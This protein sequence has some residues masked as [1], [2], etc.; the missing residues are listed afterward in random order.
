LDTNPNDQSHGEIEAFVNFTKAVMKAY[1]K[2]PENQMKEEREHAE[3]QEEQP[4]GPKTAE[5]PEFEDIPKE[6]LTSSLDINAKLTKDQRSKLEKILTINHRAFSLDGRIGKYEDIKYKIRVEPGATPISLPPYSASL[7]KRE[8]IDKQLDKW[9]SQEVIEPSD[10]PWGA[11]VIVVYRFGKPRVCIDYRGVNSLSQPDEYPLPKQTDILQA[12]MG[13]Q[14]LSTF[15]TL[16]GFQQ[17]EIKET[18]RPISAFRCHRG[19]LQFKRLPFGLR[20]GP[21]VFQ[22]IMNKVLST[23]LWLFVLV[24]IDDIV[25]Y[26]KTFEDHL[27]HLDKVL[28]AII[29]ANITLSPPKCHIGYQSLILLGQKVSRLG[30]STLKEKV[31]AI[32]VLIPPI[33]VSELQSFLGMVNYFSNY[34]PFY[35][36]ITRP[37]Y[38]LLRKDTTWIW[39]DKQQRAFDLC[40]EALTAAPVLGYPIPGLGYRLYTDASDHG[41]GVVLQ[42]IQPIK[43]KDLKG[44]KTY[45]RL[46]DHYLNNQPIPLLTTNIKLE[47][48]HIPTNLLWDKEFEET[49]VWVERVIAYWSRL[50]KQ[51]EK[52]Y[53]ATEKEAL[54]LKEALVKFQ[55]V[56]EGEHIMAI[57]DHSALTWSKTY[58]NVNKRLQKWGLTYNAYPKLKIIHRARRVHSNVYPISRLHRR[59]PW[60]ESP[61]FL[62]DPQIELK[63][64]QKIDFY[65]KYRNK[66]ESMAYKIAL[67]QQDSITFTNI[68]NESYAVAYQ[69]SNKMETQLHFNENDIREWI[70]AYEKDKHYSEVLQ[71]CGVSNTKFSQYSLQEDGIIIFNNWTGYSRVCVPKSLVHEILKEI[72]DGITG[73]AHA[74]YDK[75]YKRISQIFYWLKMS[76]DIKKFVYSCPICQQIKHKRH[77]PYGILQL[78]PIPDKPF[79]VVTM[80]LITDLP[81]SENYNAIYV[82][83]CKL[84]KYAFFIPCTTKLSEKEAAKIFFDNIVCHVGLPIQI[85]SD[86]DSRWRNDFWKEVCQYM[87]S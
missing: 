31:D 83:V 81:E 41:I 42:Q 59:I 10:S 60:Y 70:N 23:M 64:G 29:K 43:I 56:L 36:W 77:S 65:E 28:K 25:V 4:S 18:H 67:D 8:A 7:E 63:E 87:G 84:T 62:N 17:V 32:Q 50:F 74:E 44:T 15:D 12:L 16:S 75:T 22:R 68:Q 53:S 61:D 6:L 79:E 85:I 1:R 86:R 9:H 5:V 30:I 47:E 19:L 39:N 49:Q 48:S 27:I 82:I 45:D 26:S 24:Y 2:E 73:T 54:A 11:P 14:W 76:K 46:K 33:K 52:N 40:K 51:A 78:I 66:V 21:Q 71:A 58:Q 20:N 55:P 13:S 35:S 3:K 57:T 38:S 34:I 37:L 72:H 69:V 80:D